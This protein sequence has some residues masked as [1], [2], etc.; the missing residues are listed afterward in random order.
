MSYLILKSLAYPCVRAQEFSL[1]LRFTRDWGVMV[2]ARL[3]LSYERKMKMTFSDAA[4]ARFDLSGKTAL[5][6]GSSRGIGFAL[7]SGLAEAGAHVILNSRDASAIKAASDKI[8]A[9]EGSTSQ[10]IFD[11]TDRQA[12]EDAI[13]GFEQDTGP[14][15]ILINNAGMQHRQPLENFDPAAFDRVMATNVTA[16]FTLSQLVARHMI[17][18]KQGKIINIASVMTKAARHMIG[19]YTTSKAAV[20]GLTRAMTAEWAQHGI[21]CNAIGPGYFST[22]LTSALFNQEEFASWL[23]KR[24]PAGR[25]GE[26]DDLVGA[27]LF[28]SAPA[29]NYVNGHVLYVDGGM[30]ATIG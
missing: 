20:A 27:A 2:K 16:V 6:T 23:R 17:E 22:E 26:V 4:Q 14:I 10:L 28:L 9:M 11:V 12:A 8:T 7:A 21:G 15:D 25:W 13:N 29:S 24:T 30:T 1:G 3:T 18:R 5:I 19:A